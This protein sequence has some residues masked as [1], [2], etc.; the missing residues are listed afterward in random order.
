MPTPAVPNDYERPNAWRYRDYV[1]RSFNE[2]K[3][4][5]QFILE[6]IAGDELVPDNTEKRSPPAFS[7]AWVRTAIRGGSHAAA[8][9]DD[10]TDYRSYVLG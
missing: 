5:D 6:Q 1:I 7:G 2:D 4:Y 9:L 3:P 8:Y 10:V